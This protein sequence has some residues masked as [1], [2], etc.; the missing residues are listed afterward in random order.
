[1]ELVDESNLSDA[2]TLSDALFDEEIIRLAVEQQDVD[3]KWFDFEASRSSSAPT[4]YGPPPPSVGLF[5]A[6]KFGESPATSSNRVATSKA[7]TTNLTP[8]Y[9]NGT[10]IAAPSNPGYFSGIGQQ[11]TSLRNRSA[12]RSLQPG[13]V[14]LHNLGK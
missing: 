10:V 12:A 7:T 6:G 5:S 8:R 9:K 2:S 13:L 3:G 1:M 4:V 14:G 11:I